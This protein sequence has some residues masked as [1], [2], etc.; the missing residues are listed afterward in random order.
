MKWKDTS[1]NNK[2]FDNLFDRLDRLEATTTDKSNGMQSLSESAESEFCFGL[3]EEQFSKLTPMEQFILR[4]N[5]QGREIRPYYKDEVL[6]VH[7][8]TSDKYDRRTLEGDESI[9]LP[10]PNKRFAPTLY[11]YRVAGVFGLDWQTLQDKIARG[12]MKDRIADGYSH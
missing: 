9:Y 3:T 11:K 5:W 4:F 12:E 10:Q 7:N 6:R 1:S 2:S 8:I